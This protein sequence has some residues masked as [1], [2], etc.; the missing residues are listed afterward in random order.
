[1]PITDPFEDFG[2][3]AELARGLDDADPAVRRVAVL[4]LAETADPDAVPPLAR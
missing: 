3:V 4:A 1:M 2:D